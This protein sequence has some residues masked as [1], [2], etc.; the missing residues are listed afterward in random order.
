MPASPERQE[1]SFV[2]AKEIRRFC[3]P[4]L[5]EM[6][7]WLISRLK[8]KFEGMS[9]QAALG[10]LRGIMVSSEYNFVRNEGAVLLAQVLRA[11]I[12]PQ[13]QV[14]EIFCLCQDGF[15]KDGQDLYRHLARWAKNVGAEE[16]AVL[17][18]SD[19]PKP[20]IEEAMGAR[21][22]SRPTQFVRL[23]A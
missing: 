11:G 12:D 4:D 2:P 10:W 6:G 16:I 18:F 7:V 9:D 20:M 15:L 19:V 8:Q 21:V 22:S 3:Q 23:K 14:R 5:S 13:P 17:N 1:V